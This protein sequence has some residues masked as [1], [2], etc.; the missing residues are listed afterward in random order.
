MSRFACV[1]SSVL[2]VITAGAVQ[3]HAGAPEA[4]ALE[5]I[6]VADGLVTRMVPPQA[7]TPACSSAFEGVGS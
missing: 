3:V 4:L 5:E 6:T 1:L 2:V 7:M